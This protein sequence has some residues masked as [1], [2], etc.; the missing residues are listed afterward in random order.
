MLF[1]SISL[2][3]CH[4]FLKITGFGVCCSVVLSLGGTSS[5]NQT[6]I[7]QASS[8]SIPSGPMSY[9]ICPC[10]NSVCRIRFDF[11]VSNFKN[12]N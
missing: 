8:N 2:I 10:D 4:I 9:K 12:K 6:Y 5:L 11:T 7:V 3:I 1:M